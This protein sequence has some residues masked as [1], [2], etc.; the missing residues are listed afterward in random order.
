MTMSMQRERVYRGLWL[1]PSPNLAPSF[2][3]LRTAKLHPFPPGA[4]ARVGQRRAKGRVGAVERVLG[5]IVL[6]LDGELVA[7]GRALCELHLLGQQALRR[8]VRRAQ[9]LV[10]RSEDVRRGLVESDGIPGG[11]QRLHP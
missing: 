5:S 9:R 3:V 6:A 8:P 7:P 2:T 4:K 10:G 11:A 1:Y